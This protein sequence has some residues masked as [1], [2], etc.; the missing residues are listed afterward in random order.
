MKSFTLAVFFSL[1]AIFA[2]QANAQVVSTSSNGADAPIVSST[3]VINGLLPVLD[4]DWVGAVNQINDGVGAVVFDENG[5]DI[6]GTSPQSGNITLAGTY[7]FDLDV[8][9]NTL[10]Y[11]IT[12]VDVFSSWMDARAGHDFDLL[13]STNGGTTFTSVIDDVVNLG[14]GEFVQS[15]I[16]NTSGVL[17][18]TGVTNVQFNVRAGD[19]VGNGTVFREIDVFGVPTVP[20]PSSMVVLAG[21]GL[22]LL[23]RRR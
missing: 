4:H 8:S 23:R 9:T 13:F 11:D 19:A 22:A 14:S 21:F 18:G 7:T 15:T 20:E 1:A 5:I 2:T 6:A 12:S 10:G 16:S 3:D 17:L